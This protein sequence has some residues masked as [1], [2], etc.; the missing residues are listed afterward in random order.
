MD[1]NAENIY[2]QKCL[3]L[4]EAR[5]NR[6]QSTD[7]TSYDFEKLSDA[8]Q[9]TTG[10]TLSITT[11]K[12]IWGKLPYNNIPATTTLNT[13]AL[14]SGFRDWRE[15][16]QQYTPTP[17][18]EYKAA[19]K[20]I[21]L[22]WLYLSLLCLPVIG[23]LLLHGKA[24]NPAAYSFSSNKVVTEGVP[25][26]VIFKYDASAA[27][28]DSVFIAQTWD[29][30]RKIGVSKD[31]KEYSAI[32]YYPGYF[33][34]KLMIGKQIVKEHDLL[35]T[36]NGWVVLIDDNT[37]PVYLKKEE[38]QK[39]K[40][41][42]V[43]EPTIRSYNL[44]LQPQA[45]MLRFINVL[46]LGGIR[47]DNFTLETSVK[48]DFRQGSAVCQRVDILILC[49]ADVISIPLCAKACVGDLSLHAAGKSVQSKD[50]DL[51]KFGCDLSQWVNLRVETKDR[52]MRFIVNGEEAYALDFPNLPTDI[53]G[54]QYRFNGIGAVKDTR[55][56]KGARVISL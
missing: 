42:E 9:E 11:L 15:F 44:T 34:A 26:S 17:V 35:I 51:S 50:A 47:D 1:Y 37:V 52:H 5:F 16:K 19:P 23:Y 48:S 14:F 13:L 53:V 46:D 43:D 41:I 55:F 31:R 30:R 21:S 20:K 45:P 6:G 12:R 28:T 56:I 36:S 22:K 2:I 39:G 8:I 32:Y 40:T 25:N 7:W 33:R 3:V 29:T 27:G 49:K 4:I 38:F 54:L 18:T 24:V 10:V